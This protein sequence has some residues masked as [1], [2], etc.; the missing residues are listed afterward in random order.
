MPLQS[1]DIVKNNTNFNKCSIIEFKAVYT[2]Y[3]DR[4]NTSYR[5]ILMMTN[6]KQLI[7]NAKRKDLSRGTCVGLELLC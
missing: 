2:A 5:T 6:V 7:P 4:Q 3:N 1:L